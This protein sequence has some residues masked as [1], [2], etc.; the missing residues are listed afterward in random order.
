MPGDDS[1]LY[2][3]KFTDKLVL[4]SQQMENRLVSACDTGDYR[5]YE[6]GQAVDQLSPIEVEN[7]TARFEEMTPD[8][9]VFD[10]R[11]VYP[12][13]WDR[14][15]WRDTFDKIRSLVD[16]SPQI[17]RA[18]MAA[19]NRKKDKVIIDS[20]FADARTGKSGT[21]TTSFNTAAP[22]AG[23]NRIAVTVG[24]SGNVGLNVEKLI[25]VQ[26]ALL[27]NEVDLDYDPLYIGISSLQHANLLREAT[28]ISSD[29]SPNNEAGNKKLNDGK[30]SHFMG[31]DFI[32]TEQLPTSSANIRRCPVWA[33]SGMHFGTWMDVTTDIAQIKDR[34][35]LPWRIYTMASFGATRIEEKKVF[36]ILCSEV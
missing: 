5:G 28:V 17:A 4:L 9:G 15:I 8:M 24:G 11:W 34:R 20:F 36:E 31:F 12:S 19:M 33:K 32:H 35:G 7:K 13:D 23:G 10:Q 21:A 18:L 6:G 27:A 30:I 25:Q 22:S 14:S 29:F 3:L 26:Q 2:A 1:T 16:T